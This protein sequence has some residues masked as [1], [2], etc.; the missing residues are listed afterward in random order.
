M[1]NKDAPHQVVITI[2]YQI[3]ELDKLGRI[4]PE[5]S[6]SNTKLLT[7]IGNNYDECDKYK[8]QFLER[9]TNAKDETEDK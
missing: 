2:K 7:F 9:V 6:K 8:Q 1:T 4:L 5:G 3:S